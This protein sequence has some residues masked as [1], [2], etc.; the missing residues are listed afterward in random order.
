MRCAVCGSVLRETTEPIAE[1]IRGVDT[2]ACGIRHF[3]CDGCGEAEM[4]LADADRLASEQMRQVAKAKGLL[5]PDEIRGIRKGLGLTQ[6]E[7]QQL[8]GVSSPA[9][10]RWETGAM[11]PSKTTDTL[12]RVLSEVPE[13][14]VFLMRRETDAEFQVVVAADGPAIP[15]RYEDATKHDV[16]M[17]RIAA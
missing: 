5:S 2:I 15:V 14:V 17:Q 10:S 9:V 8:L 16:D 6:E 11:L 12:M 3:V 4:D 1:R 13:A 7:F